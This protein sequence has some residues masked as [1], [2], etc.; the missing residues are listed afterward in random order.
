MW[1]T[2]RQV[3][4]DKEEKFLKPFLDMF[5]TRYEVETKNYHDVIDRT[6]II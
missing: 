2:S 3:F 6:S 5:A 4:N 1:F